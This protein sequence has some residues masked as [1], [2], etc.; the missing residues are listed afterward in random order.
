MDKKTS[1]Y[2]FTLPP[3][4]PRRGASKQASKH[5]ES[6]TIQRAQE[7]R[8]ASSLTYTHQTHQLRGQYP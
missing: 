8:K 6:T 4:K 5:R 3:L 1:V 2:E 7:G